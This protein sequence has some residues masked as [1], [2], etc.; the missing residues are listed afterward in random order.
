MATCHGFIDGNKRTAWVLTVLLIERSGYTLEIR[1]DDRIDD[2]AVSV[3]ERTM[4]EAEFEMWL[5]ERIA[6]S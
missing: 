5:K 2:I 4:S 1:D 6:R 3:V